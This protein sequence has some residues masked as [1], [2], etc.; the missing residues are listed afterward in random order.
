M[1]SA[2]RSGAPPAAVAIARSHVFIL[3]RLL[4]SDDPSFRVGLAVRYPLAAEPAEINRPVLL[5]H[6]DLGRGP[7]LPEKPGRRAAD[8]APADDHDVRPHLLPSAA[9]AGFVTFL[10]S[11]AAS[12][13]MGWEKDRQGQFMRLGGKNAIIS[14]AGSGIGRAIAVGFAAEGAGVVVAD[15]IADRALSTTAQIREAG[16]KAEA[17]TADVSRRPEVEKILEAALASFQR[18]HI[19]VSVAGIATV[20]PFLELPEAEWDEIMAVNL[21]SQYLCGQIVGRHMAERGGGSIINVTSQ[22]ADVAQPMSAHY[23]ASKGGGKMLTKSM[24]LDLVQF[25][26]RVNALAPGLTDGGDQSWMDTERGRAWRPHREKLHERIPMHR[27][28]RPEEMVGAAVF[29]AS[30]EASYVTGST[31]LVDGGYLAI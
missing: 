18:I 24:A 21:K 14:G 31:L 11:Y 4:G 27:A 2:A 17:V 5:Q 20:R 15:I 29:L 7:R 23:Q 8:H 3:R 26:I 19:L 1:D 12:V 9:L 16:G 22:L 25:N 13:I 6:H 28:A 30:D 10:A